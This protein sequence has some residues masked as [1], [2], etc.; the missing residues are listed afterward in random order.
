[1]T[2]PDEVI[3]APSKK[4]VPDWA[5]MYTQEEFTPEPV[6]VRRMRETSEAVQRLMELLHAQD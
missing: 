1:M 2:D 6:I 5:A 4:Q 3:I